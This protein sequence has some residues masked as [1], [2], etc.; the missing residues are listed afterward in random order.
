VANTLPR[1]NQLQ[2]RLN[3]ALC[4][5]LPATLRRCPRRL[6]ADLTLIPYHG[7]P[8][9]DEEA[10]IYRGL[11]RNGTTHFH[12]C[13]RQGTGRKEES[14]PDKGESRPMPPDTAGNYSQNV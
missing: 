14:P 7:Q 1:L 11:A 6:A 4:D 2:R 13:A 5:G 3:N 12:A 10:T 9:D 8:R